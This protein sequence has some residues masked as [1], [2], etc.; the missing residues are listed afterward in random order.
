MARLSKYDREIAQSWHDRHYYPIFL[1]F[2]AEQSRFIRTAR[3]WQGMT[4]VE[5]GGKNGWQSEVILDHGG[6]RALIV[7]GRQANIDQ[8]TPKHPDRMEYLCADVRRLPE[9]GA[10]DA[11]LV[12]GLLYH[13][14]NPVEFIASLE[15]YV[16]SDLLFWTHTASTISGELAG[17]RGCY[18]NDT[19]FGDLMALEPCAAFWFEKDE[20]VRCFYD[21]GWTTQ[22]IKQHRSPMQ[23]QY[24]AYLIHCVRA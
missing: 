18:W 1:E 7:E 19:G 5:F 2:H 9:I 12:F 10:F 20:L 3:K 16:K 22:T 24:D 23:P 15:K 4:V 21:Y 6:E 8:A 11:G 13:L 14:D 17:Y